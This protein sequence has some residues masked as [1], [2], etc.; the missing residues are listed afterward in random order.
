MMPIGIYLHIPFCVKKC[1]YCDFVSYAGKEEIITPYFDALSQELAWYVQRHL[2]DDYRPLTL[3]VG[4]GTPSL[5]TPALVRFIQNTEK[6]WAFDTLQERT[7]EV[8]PGTITDSQLP[9]LRQAGFNRISIGVQ[10]LHNRE[11]EILGRI[12]TSQEAVSCF[13]AAREAGFENINLDLIFGIPTSDLASWQAT[14]EQVICLNPEHLSLYNLTIEKETPFWVLQQQGKLVLPDEET[15]LAMYQT[16]ITLLTQAGY[17]HYEISNFARPGCRSQHNQ[18]YWRNEEYLGLGAGATSYIRG[19]RYTNT[20]AVEDYIVCATAD[21]APYPATVVTIEKLDFAAT[22]GETIMMNLRL[23]EGIDLTAFSRRFGIALEEFH[24]NT[25][26][27]LYDLNLIE[28]YKNHI[29]L[30]FRGV[31]LSNEVFQ[32]FL[33]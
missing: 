11:L 16:G 29:R 25:L 6:V 9:Q 3:Y 10:S 30:T 17:E 8:N 12:H 13:Q 2:F 1:A 27:K 15:Q 7:I 32:E 20:P 24:V 4:G 21:H 23:I 5:T 19:C 18:I 22:I 31:L 26:D 28:R 33:L 14:L